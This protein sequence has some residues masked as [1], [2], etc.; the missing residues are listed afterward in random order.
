MRRVVAGA[1][2]GRIEGHPVDP[3][4]LRTQ[5]AIEH[6]GEGHDLA[7]IGVSARLGRG[8]VGVGDVLGDEVKA[9][10]LRVERAL[11]IAALDADRYLAQRINALGGCAH[12]DTSDDPLHP[13]NRPRRHRQLL[14]A[15]PDER[16]RH[17]RLRRHLTADDHRNSSVSPSLQSAIYPVQHS[18]MQR[19]KPCGYLVVAAID[20]ECI[21]DQIVRAEFEKIKLGRDLL[22]GQDRRR[23][24]HHRADRYFG[25]RLATRS[26]TLHL[27]RDEL[28]RSGA[29]AVRR[30]RARREDPPLATLGSGDGAHSQHVQSDGA[31]GRAAAVAAA[32]RCGGE[33]QRAAAR[34]GALADARP[35]DNALAPGQLL[36]FDVG[37]VYNGYWSDVGRTAVRGE[38]D[39]LQERRYTAILAGEERQLEMLRP[40]VHARELFDAAV[41]VVE[42]AGLTPYRRHHCGH[43]IG[44]EIYEPPI[45][46]PGWDETLDADMTFCLETPFYELGWGGMMVEDT[47]VVTEN[48]HERLTLSD[49][50]LRVIEG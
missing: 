30:R 35:T 32:G 31:R 17:E 23:H 26:Q 22:G 36:R 28:L 40:G 29:K 18:R 34:L 48:G 24:F 50:D 1:E 27:F 39:E 5:R 3:D 33:C 4:R 44:M 21:L 10:L 45:V 41:E 19:A 47:V 14:H 9:K 25:K 11:S 15:K 37:C 16:V 12:R 49:R 13:G 20:R 2:V 46:A 7:A 38:P 43:G 6:V 8:A 42:E